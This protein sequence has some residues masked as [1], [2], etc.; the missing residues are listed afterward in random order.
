MPRLLPVFLAAWRL[1]AQSPPE[2]V[3]AALRDKAAAVLQEP[4]EARRALLVRELSGAPEFLRALVEQ[5]SSPRVRREILAR[6]GRRTSPEIRQTLE[7]LIAT[8]PDAGI[9]I[10]ALEQLRVQQAQANLAL[11]ERRLQAATPADRA[12]LAAEHERTVALA[13]G[14]RLPSFFHRPPPVFAVKPAA[15][16]IRVLA[17]GDYGQGTPGQSAAAAAMLRFHRQSPFDFAI[18]LGDNFYPRGMESPSDPRWKTLWDDLYNPLRIPFYVS[19]GNHDYGMPDS[20]AAELLYGVH[21]PTWRLPATR[22]TFTAYSHGAHGDTPQLIRE[23]LP[24]LRNRADA[25]FAGHEHD[26]QHLKPEDGVH[27]FISGGGG[28]GIRPITPGER[29]LFAKSSYGF[30][31]LEADPATLKVSYFDSDLHPL[32]DYTLRK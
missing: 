5:E 20:P 29:S 6:I 14:A 32:Y 19:F 25:Y 13:R 27:L 21:S 8:D 7:Q 15:Q 23:L 9:S 28:A 17:F 11:F 3:P 1:L 31:V 26:L 2:T 22:Y 18:T 30:A 10:L 16:P 24:L 4:D 12:L